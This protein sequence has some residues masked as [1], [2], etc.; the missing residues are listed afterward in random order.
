MMQGATPIISARDLRKEFTLAIHRGTFKSLILSG[1]KVKRQV[2][3]A[4]QGLDLEIAPGESV[5]LLGRN[6][7]GK[8]TFLSLVGRIYLPTS[9][10]LEVRGRVA[11][12]LEL[13]AGFHG[14]LNGLENIEL[15]G[16]ILG[17]TRRQVAERLRSI[18]DFAE[19]GHCIDAPLRTYSS[20]MVA[21]LGFAVAVHTEADILI[22]DEVLA[23]GDEEF[24]EKCFARIE[25][26]KSEGKTLLIV[27]HEMNDV[28][29]VAT[30]VV[31]LEEGRVRM[32][33]DPQ[34]V[35]EAYLAHSHARS[36][37]HAAG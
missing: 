15:N 21:R 7:S 24:Q 27:S 4:L 10:T 3:R 25:Q 17:L 9:G 19:L 32:D 1:G 30:R 33:G 16:V 11:P 6:G 31:W 14:D 26:F 35:V 20:G 36:A 29:R 13:G 22:V 12:L 23:V 2:V 8:S 34:P 5:A 37:A 28:L 18:V